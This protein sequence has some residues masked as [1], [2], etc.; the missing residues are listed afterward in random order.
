M[1]TARS[2]LIGC[3]RTVQQVLDAQPALS[4]L[5]TWTAIPRRGKF[6]RSDV[7]RRPG[8]S[9]YASGSLAR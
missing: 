9:T 8:R 7:S 4:D 6:S 2:A 5:S 3:D 1:T